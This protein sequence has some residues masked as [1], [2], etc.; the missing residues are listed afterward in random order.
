MISRD[1]LAGYRCAVGFSNL[2]Q[3][4]KDYL[5][6]AFLASIYSVSST[7]FVFKGGTALQKTCGLDRFSEDLD[8]TFNAEAPP[9]KFID[10]AITALKPF[11]EALIAS[12]KEQPA[13]FTYRVKMKGPLYDGAERTMHSITLEINKR[14]KILRKPRAIKVVPLYSDLRPYVAY[15]MAIEEMLAEK[16]RAILTR[17]KA[18]DVYDLWFLLRKNTKCDLGLIN[19]KLEY[20]ALKFNF[21]EFRQSI[22]EKQRVWK[23]ELGVLLKGIPDFKEVSGYVLKEVGSLSPQ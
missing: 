7:E 20:Y 5:Q 2:G 1:E 22:L 21:A 3:L 17:N 8:F 12:K 23:P 18:R 4:E 13:S 14:E 16:I 11:T 19:K 6:H 10:E 9:A 15:V